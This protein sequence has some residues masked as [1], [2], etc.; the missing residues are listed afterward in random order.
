MRK[1]RQM[2]LKILSNSKGFDIPPRS[3][4]FVR[5]YNQVR[6]ESKG[7]SLYFIVVQVREHIYKNHIC[8]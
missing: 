8:N 6:N 2:N 3:R 4:D 7:E 5:L 1:Y